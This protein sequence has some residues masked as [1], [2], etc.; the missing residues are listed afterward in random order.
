[1]RHCLVSGVLF[2]SFLVV[3]C[4]D[5]GGTSDAAPTDSAVDVAPDDAGPSDSAIDGGLVDGGG[6][7]GSFP[8]STLV[9]A[10]V[11]PGAGSVATTPNGAFIAYLDCTGAPEAFVLDVIAREARDLGPA[12]DSAGGPTVVFDPTGGYV[13]FGAPSAPQLRDVATAGPAFPV[14]AGTVSAL[15]F[16]ERPDAA[17]TTW[18]LVAVVEAGGALDVIARD[19]APASGQP[20]SNS[21]TLSADIGR[22]DTNLVSSNGANIFVERGANYARV[23]TLEGEAGET[24]AYGPGDFVLGPA[25]LGNTHGIAREGDGLVFLELGTEATVTLVGAQLTEAEPLVFTQDVGGET[26]AYFVVDGDPTRRLRN[27]TGPLEM[28]ADAVTDKLGPSPDGAH[29]LYRAARAVHSVPADGSGVAVQVLADAGDDARWLFH[30]SD[31]TVVLIEGGGRV[32]RV[33]VTGADAQVLEATTVVSGSAMH[34]GDTTLWRATEGA[35][36][37]TNVLRSAEPT[38][39]AGTSIAR[40]VDRAWPLG[41]SRVLIWRTGGELVYVSTLR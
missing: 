11:C 33:G 2:L 17:A 27:G 20:Y 26:Y 28:L 40:E 12:G 34:V 1:M 29:V 7:A 5:D 16:V 24:F 22:W 18:S 36:G 37:R 23:P 9:A 38:E 25:G 21:R 4:G 10:N 6:D 41:D 14:S 8:E 19:L 13:L 15:R 31:P 32:V 39:T 3:G 35:D 30:P